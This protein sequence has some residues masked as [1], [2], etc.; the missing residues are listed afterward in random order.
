MKSKQ[1]DLTAGLVATKGAAAPA[2]DM[3]PRAPDAVAAPATPVA[4]SAGEGREALVPLNFRVP[5][6]FRRKYKTY[7]A[8]HDMKLNELLYRCFERYVEAQNAK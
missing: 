8:S 4:A 6:T 2:A 5:T 3:P 7:A 1:A